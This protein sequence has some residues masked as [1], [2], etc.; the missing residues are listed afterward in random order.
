M[1]KKQYPLVLSS[2]TQTN[3][4]HWLGKTYGN[5]HKNLARKIFDHLTGDS[6]DFQT[7]AD[8]FSNGVNWKKRDPNQYKIAD[9]SKAHEAEIHQI[10]EKLDVGSKRQY[11]WGNQKYSMTSVIRWFYQNG[12][13]RDQ[14]V[15]FIRKAGLTPAP[16]TIVCQFD[17]P[18]HREKS[19]APISNDDK[20]AIDSILDGF[21]P[22]TKDNGTKEGGTRYCWVK[23]VCRGKVRQKKLDSVGDAIRCE[24]CGDKPHERN[25]D[26]R[27]VYAVDHI[28]PLGQDPERV[29]L[30]KN[31]HLRI[32]CWNC[33]AT[34][35]WGTTSFEELK[36]LALLQN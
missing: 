4:V 3:F 21:E 33:H 14:T 16:H 19:P 23:R 2:Y 32:V 35:T 29:R 18:S 36:K 9:V 27:A 26:D 24:C 8:T 5:E 30:T 15:W 28:V 10:A 6:G 25:G 34:F 7:F 20:E 31:E 12:Y 22:A 11:L 13:H 17:S 1:S